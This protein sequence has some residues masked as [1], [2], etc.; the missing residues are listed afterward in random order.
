MGTL[1]IDRKDLTVKLDGNTL[2]FYLDGTREG[3]VPVN[4]LKRVVIVGSV[5]I[6]TPVIHRLVD[7][8]ASILF[9]SGR[10]AR[11]RGMVTGG[12]HK[13]GLLRRTQ[14]EKSLSLFGL[15]YAREL[16]Q[17]K[18]SGQCA[19]LEEAAA[20]RPDL[21]SSLIPAAAVL[22]S[23]MDK[24]DGL[25]LAVPPPQGDESPPAPEHMLGTLTGLEGGASAAYFGAFSRLFPPSLNFRNRN[26]RPP[27]DPVN[28]LLSLTYTLLHYE[29]LREIEMIGMDPYIGFLHQF[30]YGRAS[31]ACDL[32]EIFRPD[33]DRFVWQLFRTEEFSARDFTFGEEGHGC[34]LK[35]GGRKRFYTLYEEWAR[36]GRAGITDQTRQ[37]AR[38]IMDGEDP[39]PD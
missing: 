36:E 25:C 24:L 22:H 3:S 5:S 10:R 8:G 23:V 7:N 32:V 21:R 28:A 26:R 12:L 34:Y 35:K 20:A 13:N 6:E 18:V 11:F 29:V 38:R 4:P 1:Y 19:L 15:E 31:L 39:L 27:R 30:E 9:L 17:R 33:A 14:Y 37:L 16:V 2:A